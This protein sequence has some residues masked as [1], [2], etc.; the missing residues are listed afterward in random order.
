MLQKEKSFAKKYKCSEGERSVHAL[1]SAA[2][3][4]SFTTKL[5]KRCRLN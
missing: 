1:R 5:S 2:L 3:A 4:I